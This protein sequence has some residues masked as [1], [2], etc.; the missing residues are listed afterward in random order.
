[1][2]TH[3]KLWN[4]LSP[5]GHGGVRPQSSELDGVIVLAKNFVLTG[6]QKKLLSRGLSFIPSLDIGKGQKI[7]LELDIQKYHRKIKLAAYFKNS[8]SR[9]RVMFVGQ[10]DWEPPLEKLPLEV[11]ILI[12][13]DLGRFKKYYR[14]VRE[15]YNISLEEVK[16]MRELKHAR[17]VVIKPA[18]KGSAIVILDREQYIFEAE[19]Q[20]KDKT[21]YKKLDK[22]VYWETIPMVRDVLNSLQKK[23]FINRK[24][25]TYLMGNS[26]P[27]ER[28]FYVLPKIHKEPEKWTIPYE[29]P[30]GRP[31]VSDCGSDTCNTAE[32][33]DFYLGPLSTK[34]P[35]YLKDTYHFVSKVKK[36]RVLTDFYFFTMDVDNLYTN[37]PIQAGIAAV[38][39]IFKKFPDCR[40]PDEELISLL[41]INLERNDFLFNDQFYLQ[42]KGT[43]MGK[44]FAPAYANI[45]MADWE[46]KAL[47]QCNQKPAHY[48]RYLDDMWGIWTGTELEFDR[49]VE[50]LNLVD[51]SIQLKSELKK[52]SIDFLDTTVFKGPEYYETRKLDVKVFFK[53]TDTHALLHRNSFHPR[54]TFKGVVKSQLMRFKRI[55]TRSEDFMNAVRILFRA[56]RKRGYSRSFLRHCFK[57]FQEKGDKL[58][59]DPLP[60]ITTFSTNSRWVNKDL[61][62]NFYTIMGKHGILPNFR[63]ISAYRKNKNLSDWLVRAKL[64]STGT[65]VRTSPKK[66]ESQFLGLQYIRNAKNKK[67][68]EI[69]QK[70]GVNSKNCVYVIL[71]SKCGKKYI[72]ETKNDLSTRMYQHRYNIRQ[73]K[74]VDTLL[75]SHFLLHGMDAIRIAG[76]QRGSNWTDKERKQKER[77]WIYRLGT[78]EPFGLNMKWN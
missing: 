13:E 58:Q 8:Q 73:K 72:G 11:G 71:C 31:I 32:Y 45:F 35:A 3:V 40:R 76:L 66:L 44:K 57:I 10:S 24:Q 63:V 20:L 59:G 39:E 46:E 77:L 51:P 56:L 22:P 25:F 50:E 17:H 14:P 36:L 15:K 5:I 74:E 1:M 41:K 12:D 23:K 9:G 18:D 30:P 26:Q 70:F 16:A 65:L 52:D 28:R 55:C 43:A 54:H 37:I 6:P 21:Y 2:D 29:V 69:K 34:H 48:V 38:Q 27:R 67:I 4:P 7:N 68:V 33:L 61:K 62:E 47:S 49:F 42:I 53:K 78:R 75:V 64:P 19:R 60:L